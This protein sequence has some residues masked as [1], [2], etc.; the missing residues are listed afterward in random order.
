MK[1]WAVQ[2]AKA[3]FSEFLQASLSEGPQLV[4]RRPDHHLEDALIAATALTH[5][6]T[7]ATCN[8]KDFQPFGVSLVNPFR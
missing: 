6:L 8:V 2:D 7:V 5:D 4:T 3:H 1:S